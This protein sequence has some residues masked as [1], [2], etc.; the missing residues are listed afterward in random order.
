[1]RNEWLHSLKHVYKLDPNRSITDEQLKRIASS[2]TD[3]IM[4]GGTL[5]ITYEDTNE[6]LRKMRKYALPAPVIQ[7]ISQLDAIVPG[8]DY[9]FIPFVLN[10]QNP[11]WILNAHHQA[12]KKYGDLINWDQVFVEGYVILNGQ[13]SAAKL[14]NS[15]TDLYVED[16]IAYANMADQMLN[17]PILYIEYSGQYGNLE[18]MKEIK[19]T[20]QTSRIFYGGG[21]QSAHQAKEMA[22]YADTIIVGNLIYEDF[23]QALQTVFFQ[24]NTN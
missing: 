5:G 2:G 17:L 22:Q 21:I 12:I 6:L 15:K 9:Y 24:K 8:F 10:A 4:V 11:D 19:K 20:V 14:T 16:V 1:V 13:S 7:E 18:W 3:A 23:D